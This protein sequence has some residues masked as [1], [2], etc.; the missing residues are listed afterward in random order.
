[1]TR[2][3]YDNQQE[4]LNQ[5]S[6]FEPVPEK[7]LSLPEAG[8]NVQI[9]NSN[10]TQILE[11]SQPHFR[12]RKTQQS[13]S[14]NVPNQLGAAAPMGNNDLQFDQPPAAKAEQE[15]RKTNEF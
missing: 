10:Q 1:M 2:L 5:P 12:E 11:D 7:K 14:F 3:S 13:Q 15:Q 8:S 6:K 9:T 4:V